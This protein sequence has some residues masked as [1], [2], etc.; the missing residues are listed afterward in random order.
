MVSR[1]EDRPRHR[2]APGQE[3]RT[4]GELC[5]GAPEGQVIRDEQ[6]SS[7]VANPLGD[8]LDLR[9]LRLAID[10][11]HVRASGNLDS[12]LTR[13]GAGSLVAWHRLF[14]YFHS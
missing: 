2:G 3:A 13:I 10:G 12:E 8:G 1:S 6:K 4:G 14:R 5:G 9:G 11:G 7:A